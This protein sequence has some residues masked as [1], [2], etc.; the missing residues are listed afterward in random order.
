MLRIPTILAVAKWEEQFQFLQEGTRQ[1]DRRLDK[2][3]SSQAAIRQT[4]GTAGASART[5]YVGKILPCLC[6]QTDCEE[7]RHQDYDTQSAACQVTAYLKH[8]SFSF[9]RPSPL[10][11]CTS[12]FSFWAALK[13]WSTSTAAAGSF[14]P[15]L[16]HLQ[17][18]TPCSLR[19]GKHYL[20][21]EEQA[22]S[23][24]ETQDKRNH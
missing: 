20:G 5:G 23:P 9:L 24:Q 22:Q 19:Y 4:Q 16:S 3:G 7:P 15:C 2:Q 21:S 10:Q 1:P 17:S 12:Q 8:K 18:W 11:V 13:L 6:F 14:P